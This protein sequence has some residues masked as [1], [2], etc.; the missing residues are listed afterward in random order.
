ME[1]RRRFG[2]TYLPYCDKTTTVKDKFG[3]SFKKN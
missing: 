2:E 1:K 3:F